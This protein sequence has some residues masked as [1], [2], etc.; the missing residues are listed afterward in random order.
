MSKHE[1]SD[2]SAWIRS[3]VAEHED[4]LLRYARRLTGSRDRAGDVVQD[5]FLRLCRQDR[6]EVE[7]HL[8]EWLY[9]VC[10]RRAI[11]VGRKENTMKTASADVQ[12][13][14]DIGPDSEAVAIQRE[15]TVQVEAALSTLSDNQQEV[16][17][18]KFQHGLSYREIAGVT[19]L[20]VSNVGYLIHTAIANIR[21]QLR[22]DIELA[23]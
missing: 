22:V 9:T 19:E 20:S 16:I 18:L 12:S 10:R 4:Q 6:S 2:N 7:G 23:P 14:A 5:V 3:A 11:D 21:R 15:E 8:A 1:A 17:R 13:Q